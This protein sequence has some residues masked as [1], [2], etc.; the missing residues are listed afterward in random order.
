MSSTISIA[1]EGPDANRA[2]DELL[3]IDGIVGEALPA[4]RGPVMRDGGVLTAVGAIVGFAG[5]LASIVSSI[6]EWRE[7]M[8]KSSADERLSVVIEDA[9][10]NRI[11]LE[12]ATP[13]QVASVLQTLQA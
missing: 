7:K 10:G 12:H 5:T 6:I 4:E 8:K 2:L 3:A 13:E 11:S 1:I 9:K